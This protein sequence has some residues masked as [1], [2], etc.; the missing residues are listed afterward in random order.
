MPD[1]TIDVDKS[2]KVIAFTKGAFFALMCV[3][4]IMTL[5]AVIVL[6]QYQETSTK[7][8]LDCTLPTGACYLEKADNINKQQE[9]LVGSAV[10]YCASQNRDSVVAIRNCVEAELRRIP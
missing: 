1:R 10:E 4:F 6:L 8:L 7:T 3:S 2:R 9:A 5:G